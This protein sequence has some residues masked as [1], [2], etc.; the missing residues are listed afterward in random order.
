MSNE[1]TTVNHKAYL[2][3]CYVN[4]E[5]NGKRATGFV[6]EVFDEGF[7]VDMVVHDDKGFP[8]HNTDYTVFVKTE[9]VY[10]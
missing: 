6:S 4:F 9:E 1:V 10:R 8:G 5:R 3:G 2:D 7:G